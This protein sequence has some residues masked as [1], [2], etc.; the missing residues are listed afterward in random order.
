MRYKKD[1]N[2]VVIEKHMAELKTKFNLFQRKI[3]QV[4]DANRNI[5]NDYEQVTKKSITNIKRF[6]KILLS[7]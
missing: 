4:I 7:I 6:N 5:Y 3:G 2:N 1:I